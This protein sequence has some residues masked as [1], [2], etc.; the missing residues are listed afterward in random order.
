MKIIELDCLQKRLGVTPNKAR[1]S[2]E[3]ARF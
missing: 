1:F 2:R 3:A